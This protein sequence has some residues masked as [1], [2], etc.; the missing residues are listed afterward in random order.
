[1][2]NSKRIK[3]L[4]AFKI[5]KKDLFKG[6]VGCVVATFL[7]A[8]AIKCFISMPGVGMLSNGIGGISLIASRLLGRLGWDVDLWYSIIHFAINIPVIIL[9]FMRIGKWYT[10]FTLINSVLASVFNIVIPT[11]L[12]SFLGLDPVADK[13][14]IALCAGVLIGVSSGIAL[15][16]GSSTGG[17]DT[18]ST[19][20]GVRYNKQIGKYNLLLNCVILL[21]G[22]LLFHDWTAMLYTI[23][24]IYVCSQIIDLI[25]RRAMKR[26]VRIVTTKKDEVCDAI[27]SQSKHGVTIFEAEGGYTHTKKYQL[28]TIVLE[29]EVKFYINIAKQVDPDCFI[30][31]LN[32]H[33]TVGRYAMPTIK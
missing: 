2:K 18:L 19:Y 28:E 7:Y 31:V 8:V 16:T 22:G 23:V 20:I 3:H 11:E 12:F 5:S 14:L 33:E 21:A 27:L 9:A 13:L 29:E 30:S 4:D 25:Y 15:K 1:M 10:I 24:F 6:L 26:L 32:I 17:I